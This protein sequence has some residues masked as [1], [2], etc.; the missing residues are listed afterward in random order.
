MADF[1]LEVHCG[2]MAIQ[3]L[4]L[5]DVYRQGSR[6]VMDVQEFIVTLI[7]ALKYLRATAS[8]SE[9]RQL[10]SEIDTDRDGLITYKEY[11]EF[12]K[13]YFGSGSVAI[14]DEFNV[15][16]PTVTPQPA[17]TLSLED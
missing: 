16:R 15:V 11:F 14:Y 2:E 7:D 17:I 8:E 9:L 3:R 13:L 10:F 1:L 4:H 6:R 12:L 5:R